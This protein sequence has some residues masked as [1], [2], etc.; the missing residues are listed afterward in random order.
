MK[1]PSNRVEAHPS[2]MDFLKIVRGIYRG[3]QLSRYPRV[4]HTR[5]L[6]RGTVVINAVC[7]VG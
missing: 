1:E 3:V 4:T 6:L 5:P 2:Q 7:P